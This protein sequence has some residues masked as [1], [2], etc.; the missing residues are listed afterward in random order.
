MRM[1]TLHAKF[2]VNLAFGLQSF[3]CSFSSVTFLLGHLLG[4][5]QSLLLLG[6]SITLPLLY[7]LSSPQRLFLNGLL[8]RFLPRYPSALP[9]LH[10]L[11]SFADL[12]LLLPEAY[13]LLSLLLLLLPSAVLLLLGGLHGGDAGGPLAGHGIQLALLLLLARALAGVGL[14]HGSD[15]LHHV[16]A[17]GLVVAVLGFLEGLTKCQ[18]LL[19]GGAHRLPAPGYALRLSGLLALER[20]RWRV[21]EQV[22]VLRLLGKVV[23]AAAQGVPPHGLCAQYIRGVLLVLHAVHHRVAHQL[24]VFKGP[25]AAGQQQGET[26]IQ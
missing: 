11:L 20:G 3:G 6:L 10:L 7:Q 16:L 13:L 2:H 14:D 25:L 12:L 18:Q 17:N 9:S 22:R 1:C 21:S 15:V 8:A 4:S 26:R 5:L 19:R 24:I 23:Q